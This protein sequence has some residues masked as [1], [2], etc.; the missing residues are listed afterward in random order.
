MEPLMTILITLLVLLAFGLVLVQGI[1]S[2]MQDLLQRHVHG[3]PVFDESGPTF[4][5]QVAEHRE[6]ISQFAWQ[7]RSHFQAPD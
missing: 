6:L 3:G 4:Q 5:N 7:S 1:F 2:V